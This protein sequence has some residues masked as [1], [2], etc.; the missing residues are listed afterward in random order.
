MDPATAAIR[1]IPENA[2]TDMAKLEVC[3]KL[4]PLVGQL[5]AFGAITPEFNQDAVA[6]I[7]WDFGELATCSFDSFLAIGGMEAGLVNSPHATVYTNE[8][9]SMAR[10]VWRGIPVDDDSFAIDVIKRCGKRYVSHADPYS[11][12][13][14]EGFVE[15]QIP[16]KNIS[17]S[18][19]EKGG[20]KDISERI[21]EDLSKIL[22]AHEVEPLSEDLQKALKAIT[23]KYKG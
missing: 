18:D 13:C 10:R 15:R 16:L 9:A 5:S 20:K 14:K 19:W 11:A 12:S 4:G 8:L 1:G 22:G 17:L 3:R 23:E 21:H 7:T 6:K 2:L